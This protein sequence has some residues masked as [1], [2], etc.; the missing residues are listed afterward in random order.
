MGCSQSSFLNYS[1][2]R[3]LWRVEAGLPFVPDPALELS[4][5]GRRILSETGGSDDA[6]D[7]WMKLRALIS[8]M[9][10]AEE[11][12]IGAK[13]P[14]V[15]GNFEQGLGAVGLCRFGLSRNVHGHRTERACCE[16]NRQRQTVKAAKSGPE[17]SAY[18]K[19]RT[20]SRGVDLQGK[21]RDV[22]SVSGLHELGRVVSLF[23][24]SE[25]INEFRSVQFQ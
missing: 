4:N 14:R 25:D 3:A 7:M 13:M 18:L 23:R 10:H 16:N 20:G 11:T 15:A 19:R 1:I 8:A 17:S 2:E 22:F 21:H 9:E 12:C 6:V 24:L 5:P